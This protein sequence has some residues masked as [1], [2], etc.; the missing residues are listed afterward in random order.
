MATLKVARDFMRRKLVTL[1]ADTEVLDGVARLLRDNISG[2]SVIDDQGRYLGVFSEKCSMNAMTEVVEA[3]DACGLYSG[4]TREFMKCELF[5]L[6]PE[7]DVFEAIDEVLKRRISGAP[8][9][10]SDQHYLGIFS[11]KTAMRV[12]VSAVHDQLPGANVGSYMNFDRNRIIDD[13]DAL[14]TVAHKFQQT[15]YRRLPVL[16]HGRLAG[17]VSRRDVIR[18]EHGV[19]VAV[20]KRV[21]RGGCDERLQEATRTR[22][23]GDWMDTSALTTSPETDLLTVAMVFLNS[24]Y[25]R[26]PIVDSGK[27][28]G[29]ISRRDLLEAAA[30][31]LR[32]KPKKHHAEALYLSPLVDS[33]PPSLS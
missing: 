16:H 9:V 33:A 12:L 28:V 15:P 3:A 10:D 20:R 17:Q 29:Q 18:A 24:P 26:L 32:P 4:A 8:V 27:L 30:E 5:T 7:I 23:V 22:M 21:L 13:E 14:V 11:E 25:R 19:A 2:A 31:I 1:T 6:S